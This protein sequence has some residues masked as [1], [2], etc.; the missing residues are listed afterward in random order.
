MVPELERAIA[1]EEAVRE[2]C[3]GRVVSF[4]FGHAFFDDGFP[5]VWNVNVL[6]AER[7]AGVTAEALAAEAELLHRA[8]GHSHRRVAVPDE[9]AG[10]ALAPGFR[11]LGW[12]AERLV[13]MAYRGPGERSSATADVVEVEG[14]A[15]RP[16]RETI[17]RAEPWAEDDEVVAAVLDAG[18]LAA[19]TCP[20]RHFA[21]LANGEPVSGT[22]L[23]SDGCTAQ[24]EEVATHPDHRGRGYAS[25]VVLR[26]VHE[27]LGAGNDLVFL[28]ADDEDWPKLL[29]E[30]LGF[31]PLGRRW[32][33]LKTPSTG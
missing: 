4:R 25:A 6:R 13:L 24:V 8:A 27:A 32:S 3:A 7:T 18:E 12:Q 16:L 26:A 11:E 15:L 9:S 5:R 10:A 30:R 28:V 2:R 31:E 20:T 19:G 33:F 29:Y 21:I 22:S 23:Y 14:K 1:F 17:A